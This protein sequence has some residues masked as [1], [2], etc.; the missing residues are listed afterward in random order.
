[1]Y[2]C[3]VCVYLCLCLVLSL[4][5]LPSHIHVSIPQHNTELDSH[6]LS[7]RDVE[8]A[9]AVLVNVEGQVDRLCEQLEDAPRAAMREKIRDEIAS[10]C[11]HIDGGHFIKNK[12]ALSCIALQS[13][14][15][16]LCSSLQPHRMH[17]H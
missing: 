15:L 16:S 11:P 12:Y 2:V 14:S 7:L 5:Q 9:A 6:A 10:T 8:N 4:S 13:L 1:M 3:H 17:R